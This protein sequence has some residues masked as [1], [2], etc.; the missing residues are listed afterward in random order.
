MKKKLLIAII[1]VLAAGLAIG[2]LFLVLRMNR[3][4]A[5]VFAVEQLAMMD[6][7]SGR[8]SLYGN[9]TMDRLQTVYLSQT[10]KVTELL[11]SEGQQVHKG[12]PLLRFDTSLSQLSVQRKAL[13]LKKLERELEKDKK[14][15]NELAGKAVYTAARPGAEPG[16]QLVMLSAVQSRRADGDS[17]EIVPVPDPQTEP[18]EPEEPV[19]EV[20]V[21]PGAAPD[22]NQENPGENG[23]TPGEDNPGEEP[24]EEP[25]QPNNG[26]IPVEDPNDLD[27]N[28]VIDLFRLVSGSGTADDPYLVGVTEAYELCEVDVEGF[29]IGRTTAY[30]CFCQCTD[31]RVDRDVISAWGMCFTDTGNSWRARLFD[32]SD[33]VGSPL[34]IRDD[35]PYE[36]EEPTEPEEPGMSED[37]RK[38][39]MEELKNAINENQMK[40]RMAELEYKK[41]QRELGDGVVYAQFDGTILTVNDPDTAFVN[42]EPVIKLSGGGG[43]FIRGSISELRLGELYV[44][45][46]VEVLSWETGETFTG[47]VATISDVPSGNEYWSDGNNNVSF[48]DFT[49]RVGEEVNLPEGGWMELHL[50]SEGRQ[51]GFYLQDAFLLQENGKSYVFVRGEN[52][53]LEKREVVTGRKLW[54]ENT[55]IV[56]GLS[57]EDYIAFPYAKAT[58]PGAKTV[59]GTVEELYGW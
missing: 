23:E 59:E 12:D 37:E 47:T 22:P 19:E 53:L 48:Y 32:A 5:K 55:E 20:P 43:Y 46:P 50:I 44:G 31:N 34:V 16:V 1:S 15:Y 42:N 27:I 54:G 26:G 17:M 11:V 7:N 9:V 33:L 58:E 30:V 3:D 45:Q 2:G 18:D 57:I 10:Q 25:T 56:S 29:L 40:L 4:P 13:E 24:V 35:I 41:M 52:E 39:R 49:V 8:E 21:D 6:D 36:E 14:E 51:S 28:Y 38:Q